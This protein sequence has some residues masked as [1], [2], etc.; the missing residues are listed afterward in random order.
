[1]KFKTAK[2]R[3]TVGE[4][5]SGESAPRLVTLLEFKLK[6]ILVP[7]DFS[8]TSRKAFYY[9]VSFAR[10][11]G[12]EI[13]LLH[14]VDSA[15]IIITDPMGGVATFNPV[16]TEADP[17]KRL[18]KWRREIISKARVRMSLRTGRPEEEIIRVAVENKIDL[19]IIGRHGRTGLARLIC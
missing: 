1:M 13:L 6:K 17:A 16:P 11:F 9:A 18:A 10:E 12:A 3:R 7:V 14:V 5:K 8:E 19:L 15:P 4:L 2:K